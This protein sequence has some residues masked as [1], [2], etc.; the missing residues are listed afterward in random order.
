MAVSNDCRLLLKPDWTPDGEE[1]QF[2]ARCDCLEWEIKEPDFYAS[3]RKQWS[4]HVLNA[5]APKQSSS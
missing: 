3:I 2:L 5:A 4:N 1:Q